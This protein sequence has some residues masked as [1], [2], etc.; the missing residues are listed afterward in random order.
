MA[1]RVVDLRQQCV[2][3]GLITYG[4]KAQLVARLGIDDENALKDNRSLAGFRMLCPSEKINK[5]LVFCCFLFI[6]ISGGRRRSGA[7]V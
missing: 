2:D 4:T 3:R 7:R 1:F 6:Q 5:E